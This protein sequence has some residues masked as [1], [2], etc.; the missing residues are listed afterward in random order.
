MRDTLFRAATVGY[1]ADDEDDEVTPP[2]TPGMSIS[3]RAPHTTAPPPPT[4]SFWLPRILSTLWKK[5]KRPLPQEFR[6][7]HDPPAKRR[8]T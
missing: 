8:Q 1:V 6:N 2:S 5:E 7:D 4:M 3:P